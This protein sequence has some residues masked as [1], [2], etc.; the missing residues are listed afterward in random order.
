MLK[1]DLQHLT[2]IGSQEC[3]WVKVPMILV[4]RIEKAENLRLQLK[5]IMDDTLMFVSL[6][7]DKYKCPGVHFDNFSVIH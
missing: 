4:H 6:V 2:A 7:N 3:Q 5:A 1:Q